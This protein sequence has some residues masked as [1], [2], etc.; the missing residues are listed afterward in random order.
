MN[1]PASQPRGHSRASPGVASAAPPCDRELHGAHTGRGGHV[2]VGSVEPA[3]HY[4]P[5]RT[6]HVGLW[7]LLDESNSRSFAC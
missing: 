2:A 4:F 3:C 1:Q 6:L 5:E 7:N